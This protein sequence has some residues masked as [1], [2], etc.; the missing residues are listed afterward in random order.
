MKLTF[1]G[2]AR[3]V[4]GSKFLLELEDE[5]KILI[6]CGTDLDR[7]DLLN[8]TDNY[9][10]FPFDAS[11][12]NLV[13]LTHAHIDHSGQIPNLFI[14]GFEGQ[15]LCTSPTLELADLLLHDSANLNA[16]KLK[17]IDKSKN[18]SKKKR[19][20]ATKGLYFSRH[21][22]EALENFVPIQ[23]N[24]RFKFKDGG[25]VSFIPA[26]HLLGA[27][28]IV[29]EIVENGK[30]KKICFSGDIG[31]KNYPLLT[32]PQ[33]IPQVDYLITESTYGN[34]VHLNDEE[35]KGMLES[36]INET[37]IE[38]PGRLIIPSFSVG[39]TQSILYVLNRLYANSQLKPVK[40]FTDSPLAKASSKV[41]DK[42]TK[43][44]NKEARDFKEENDML[45]DFENLVYLD[46]EKSSREVSNHNEACIIISSSGMIQGGRVEYH[47]QQ[48]IE[49]PYATILMIGYAT[50]G[51]IGHKLISGEIKELKISGQKKEVRAAIK[52]IDVFSG[53]G[54]LNDL[55]NFV[56]SQ[57]K[58]T[59]KKIFLV[60][61]ELESMNNFKAKLEDKGFE[62]IEIPEFKQ[63]FELN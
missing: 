33:T 44:L 57:D 53:H 45:F 17:S 15:V 27:A 47:V 14:E 52:K 61:G 5:F 40:V 13:I 37:C 31:R 26:G 4:T 25:Y 54:D 62:N 55:I 58:N 12:I 19:S 59:L 16:N 34:R 10:C 49:N 30:T 51:T 32:D 42:Y 43:L 56:G 46:S 7:S 48:N 21:V 29:L 6:D 20:I 3:K 2:A 50:E 22:K 39:R 23:F 18:F 38:R 36:I 11:L 63:T 8:D 9:G 60:H 24:H 41:Y 28:H 35:S 1:F